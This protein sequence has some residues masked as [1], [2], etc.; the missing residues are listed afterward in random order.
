MLYL[1]VLLIHSLGTPLSVELYI[2][3]LFGKQYMT[4]V[5]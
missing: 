2:L 4:L 5:M 1:I 3:S